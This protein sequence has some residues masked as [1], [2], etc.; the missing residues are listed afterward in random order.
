MKLAA[1]AALF[2]RD[3]VGILLTPVT[4]APKGSDED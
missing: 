4:P 1:L 3:A 2:V